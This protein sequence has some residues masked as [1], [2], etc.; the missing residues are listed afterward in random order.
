MGINCRVVSPILR[1]HLLGRL[2]LTEFHTVVKSSTKVNYSS[3]YFLNKSEVK[4]T[5]W[6]T[7]LPY[8]CLPNFLREET[9]WIINLL[10]WM[11][12]LYYTKFDYSNFWAVQPHS[13]KFFEGENALK[14]I[15]VPTEQRPRTV[16][17]ASK[18]AS[19]SDVTYNSTGSWG[20]KRRTEIR[21][22]T[23]DGQRVSIGQLGLWREWS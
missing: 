20:E 12:L 13:P 17:R 21:K 7:L 4:S 3:N 22:L 6:V 8:N 2:Y 15:I 14:C 19:V 10:Y 23:G 11:R 1:S 5:S 18:M 16:A 9:N